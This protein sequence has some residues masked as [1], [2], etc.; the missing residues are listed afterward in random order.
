M[1][2]CG[3][4]RIQ[5]EQVYNYV[6]HLLRGS[7]STILYNINL[8]VFGGVAF[9]YSLLQSKSYK[10]MCQTFLQKLQNTNSDC[11]SVHVLKNNNKEYEYK[12]FESK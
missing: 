2:T 6:T 5:F 8:A 1:I 11:E 12:Q 3:W 4:M 9:S 7:Y 10:L